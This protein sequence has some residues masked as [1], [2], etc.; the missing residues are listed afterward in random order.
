L[1]HWQ[2]VVPTPHPI[3]AKPSEYMKMMIYRENEKPLRRNKEI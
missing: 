1:P 2:W 3:F